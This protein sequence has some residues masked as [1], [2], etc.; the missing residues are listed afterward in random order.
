[1]TVLNVTGTNYCSL[2]T[3]FVLCLDICGVYIKHYNSLE[4]K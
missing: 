1:M 3:Y 2:L 4:T